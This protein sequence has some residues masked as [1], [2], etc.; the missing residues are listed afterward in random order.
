MALPLTVP[1]PNMIEFDPAFPVVKVSDNSTR[2]LLAA[3]IADSSA[4][5]SQTANGLEYARTGTAGKIN[6]YFLQNSVFSRVPTY[7]DIT[8]C[9]VS[10][11]TSLVI[12]YT[13]TGG[14]NNLII[15]L[16]TV[17]DANTANNQTSWY[18]SRLNVVV[19]IPS[20]DVINGTIT[21]DLTDISGSTYMPLNTFSGASL[22]K[23]ASI[24]D[25][26]AN[27]QILFASFGTDSSISTPF[28]LN[29]ASISVYRA[30]NVNYT[31]NYALNADLA[32]RTNF[33]LSGLNA[34]MVAS[35]AAVIGNT[36]T[37]LTANADAIISLPIATCYDT[38]KFHS[39][40]IDSL[41]SN[42]SNLKYMVEWNGVGNWLSSNLA[43][44]QMSGGAIPFY[45]SDPD[46]QNVADDYLRFLS[47]NLFGTSE[48]VDLFSNQSDVLSSVLN[49]ST[50]ALNNQIKALAA[51]GMLPAS[52]TT[53]N[54]VSYQIMRQLLSNPKTRTRF[55]NLEKGELT[56]YIGADSFP[57][58]F[59]AVPLR[60]G[61]IIYNVLTINAAAGQETLSG[62]SA[63]QPR[64]YL[65]QFNIV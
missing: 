32:I 30:N 29:L 62:V 25:I 21:I 34:S 12:N 39:D 46:Q 47:L 10:N 38:F 6:Y 42:V 41:D 1:V 4:G 3:V 40:A 33:Y 52:N 53:N 23:A 58:Y 15:A 44:A 5:V 16:Y 27:E 9:T 45:G 26:V 19:T 36:T 20:T 56:S 65:I 2:S 61:D 48:G 59:M 8:G 64:T 28:Q 11:L 35:S 57:M 31:I 37:V 13:K 54:N 22:S 60:V 24:A 14:L 17:P 51:L 7:M 50:T 63:I 43:S 18:R 49:N 55:S